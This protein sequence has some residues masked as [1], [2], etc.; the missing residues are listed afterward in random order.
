MLRETY[1]DANGGSHD[2]FFGWANSNPLGCTFSG[3]NQVDIM[4]FRNIGGNDNKGVNERFLDSHVSSTSFQFYAETSAKNALDMK[5]Q[6][7]SKINEPL[8]SHVKSFV[9]SQADQVENPSG[10]AEEY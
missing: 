7:N 1:K 3:N 9:F 6:A 4:L 2:N 5:A 10:T 8:F